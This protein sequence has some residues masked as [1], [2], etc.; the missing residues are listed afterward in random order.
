MADRLRQ[1]G[2]KVTPQRLA[3]CKYILSRT[4]HPNTDD[5]LVEMQ[6]QYPAI[7]RSTVYNTLH[8][9][10]QIGLLQELCLE[11]DVT[12]YDPDTGIHVN[13]VCRSCGK[14][15]DIKDA[16]L[17]TAWRKMVAKTSVIPVGQRLDLYYE[18]ENCTKTK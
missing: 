11:N 18:C 6:K 5:V 14:I 9:L 10:K 3:I 17:E 2:L 12:R 16:E 13:M 1:S 15:V 8:T 4:D 7:S